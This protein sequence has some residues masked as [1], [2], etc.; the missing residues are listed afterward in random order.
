MTKYPFDGPVAAKSA[1]TPT[2]ERAQTAMAFVF[3]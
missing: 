3:T 2:R 1:S